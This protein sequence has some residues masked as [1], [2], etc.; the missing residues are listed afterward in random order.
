MR[1]L[2]AAAAAVSMEQVS[3]AVVA[4]SG[5]E[6]IIAQLRQVVRPRSVVLVQGEEEA[7]TVAFQQA[8]PEARIGVA[9]LA[10]AA[11]GTAMASARNMQVA[12]AV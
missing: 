8:E 4:L 11:A 9:V 3:V 2:A 6:L 5:A 10:A 7:L 12:L 1:Q